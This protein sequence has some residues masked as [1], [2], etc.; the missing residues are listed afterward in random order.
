[1]LLPP[2]QEKEVKSNLGFNGDITQGETLQFPEHGTTVEN[3]R[4]HSKNKNSASRQ[5]TEKLHGPQLLNR[6][7]NFK[8]P[9]GTFAK[10]VLLSGASNGPVRAQL[11][12]PV[13]LNGET[14]IDEGSILLGMGQS[15]EERLFIHFTK[16]VLKDGSS[17]TIDAQGPQRRRGRRPIVGSDHRDP[18][19]R[20]PQRAEEGRQV[21]Q[22]MGQQHRVG[23]PPGVIDCVGSGCRRY[24]PV[25][26]RV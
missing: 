14:L 26:R 10:A 17:E 7:N 22:G 8:V 6:P 1:M 15:T 11:T 5:V 25:R 4:A 23:W 16:I 9:P 19:T 18:A 2:E 3:N 13:S 21:R 12:E 20:D 24:R